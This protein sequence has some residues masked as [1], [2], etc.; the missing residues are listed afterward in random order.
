MGWRDT[1]VFESDGWQNVWEVSCQPSGLGQ[2]TQV[3][4]TSKGIILFDAFE[5]N[6]CFIF[7]K[8]SPSH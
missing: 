7:K 2:E 1:S 5:Y 3:P 6:F 4:L 8:L